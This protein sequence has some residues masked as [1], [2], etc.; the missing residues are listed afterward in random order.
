MEFKRVGFPVDFPL[1]QSNE[2]IFPGFTLKF[3]SKLWP[4][5]REKDD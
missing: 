5:N 3:T 4:F 2:I 1:N